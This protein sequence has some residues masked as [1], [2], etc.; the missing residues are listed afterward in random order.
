MR[1]Y[2]MFG[3]TVTS[4][5]TNTIGQ[6]ETLTTMVCGDVVGMAIQTHLGFCGWPI[7]KLRAIRL[8][9]SVSKVEYAVA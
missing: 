3:A 1:R 4:F 2:P 6:L 5:A 7:P 8:D 9:C